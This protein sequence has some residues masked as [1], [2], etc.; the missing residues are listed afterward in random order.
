[1]SIYKSA[2][3]KPITTLMVFAA[4]IVMGVYSLSRIPVDLYPEMEPPFISVMTSYPGANAE[5]IAGIVTRE[6]EDAFYMLDKVKEVTSI[7]SD[8]LSVITMEFAWGANLDEATNDIRDAVDRILP[9]L[10]E[11]VERP[12]IFKFNTAMMPIVFFAVT[13]EESYPGLDKILEEKIIN[14]LNR[15]EGV[16]SVGMIGVP[17]R[18]VY[19]ETDP[20]RLD[21]YRLTIEQIGSA[22]AAENLNMPAGSIRMGE[23][24]YFVRVQGELKDSDDLNDLVVGNFNGSLVYLRD[25]A[26]VRDTLVDLSLEERINGQQGLRMFVMKQSGANTVQVAE[27]VRESLETL[28][29]ELPPDINLRLIMDTSDFI[30][31]SINNLSSTLMFAFLFIILVVLFFIGKFRATII[32]ILTIPISLIVAFVYLFITDNSINVIS[33]TSLS[34]AIGMVVDDAIVVLENIMRHIERGSSPR[35]AAIY[36]TNEVW[37]SVIVTTLV[38]VAVFFPLTLVGGM[39]GVLFKQ[40]GWIVSITVVTSTIAALTLTPML[41]SQILML[42]QK[43]SN[44]PRFGYTRKVLPILDRIDDLYAKILKRA[45]RHKTVVLLLALAIFASSI[46]LL[47]FIPTDFM[48]EADD[49]SIT[50]SIELQTGTRVEETIKTT[51][52]IEA[53]INEQFPEVVVLSSSS[54]SDDEGGMFSLFQTTGS[55]IINLMM[56]FTDIE[57]RER[58]VWDIADEL[59]NQIDQLP[60]VV[61]FSVSTNG[62][63]FGGA[64][65]TVDVEIYG[66]DFDVTNDLAEQ[67]RSRLSQLDQA[68]D[69]TVS[70]KKDKPELQIELDREKLSTHGLTTAAVSGMIHNRIRGMVASRF[71]EEGEEYDIKVR[72]TEEY[73]NSITDIENL[74]IPTPMGRTVKLK[75][76]GRVKEYWG[77]PSI[78]HKQKERVVIVSATPRNASLG[79]LASLVQNEVDEIVIPQEVMVVIG[80]AFEDQQVA[81]RDLLLLML[82]SLI[83][84]FIAMA[85]QFESFKMPFVIMFSIPFAFT[86]V[87]F[88]LLITGTTLSVIAALGAVLLIGI[89]VKNG[90]ML[91][92][93]TNLMRD[94]DMRLYDAVIAAG[95]SRLRP[96]L[97]TATTTILGM[98]P[99]A[100]STGEGAE[101]WS[102]MGITVI[103]GLVFSTI[104]TM[105]LIPV[106]YCIIVRTGERDKIK[107]LRKRFLFLD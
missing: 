93:F 51:R 34:I 7:S 69:I 55:N 89:V 13:A 82:V 92:D 28:K 94:R 5:E 31:G 15:V 85:S 37:L 84:V 11:G 41:A 10:P 29:K 44:F 32:I 4:I 58:S 54:G 102:P 91:V 16:G 43:L 73:R 86:G 46:L 64:S 9:F 6:F 39:T 24:D 107:K 52:T 57:E 21:A 97:M 70:R 101:I 20:R 18:M 72:L 81:F 25:V 23:M 35:E 88:A 2:V 14:P 8:N 53:I 105:V 71:K 61:N 12:S 56:R 96:V 62:S 40:L 17:R 38:I 63:G 3:G 79:E 22:I 67:V 106:V 50:A 36:A 80:G 42:N 104:V 95:R 1:M 33:L 98:L 90:I 59:R 77:P 30:Q 26:T 99:L 78:Q 60:E 19:V 48:P 87:V 100:L 74:T 45:L 75:E 27:G 49:S 47:R 66:Y 76:L 68:T 103:G 65:N 83:L